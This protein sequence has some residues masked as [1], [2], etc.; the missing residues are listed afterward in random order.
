MHTTIGFKN[1]TMVGYQN[2]AIL[3]K[4]FT[5]VVDGETFY[6]HFV[7]ERA[8]KQQQSIKSTIAGLNAVQDAGEIVAAGSVQASYPTPLFYTDDLAL[9]GYFLTDTGFESVA[10]LTLR[11]FWPKDIRDFHSNLI[12]FLQACVASRKQYLI[13][14][15]Q[16]NPGG[17]IGLGYDVFKQLFPDLSPYAAG[18][19]RSHDQ[20]NI[21]GDFFT[22]LARDVLA[23][24][25]SIENY[26]AAG[27]F[28]IFDARASINATGAKFETWHEF[29]GPVLVHGD[30]FTNVARQDIENTSVEEYLSGFAFSDPPVQPFRSENVIVLADGDCASTCDTFMHLLKW[31]A[32][33]K[34]I[35]GGG[36]PTKGPMQVVGGVKARHKLSIGYLMYLIGIFRDK[37]PQTVQEK[38]N[39]TKL[40]TIF[41]SGEYL[42]RRTNGIFSVNLA[43]AIGKDDKTMT[44]LQFVYE[45]ADCRVWWRPEHFF[46]VRTLWTLVAGTAFGLNNTEM[47][48]AC[49]EGSTNHPSSVTG[50]GNLVFDPN[51]GIVSDDASTPRSE[52]GTSTSDGSTSAVG[53]ADPAGGSAKNSADNAIVFSTALLLTSVLFGSVVA[54]I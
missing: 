30:N 12:G 40:K 7:E 27:G 39:A 19:Q 53:K 37:A 51:S 16:A 46:N 45:A 17:N 24:T 54:A 11:S 6:R 47:W 41:E 25:G 50:G 5:G 31:Q 1:G 35:V 18:N 4:N 33:V 32:K 49:V 15:M 2:K 26:T 9:S 28:S 23:S 10:V 29:D 38:A 52:N 3:L 21:L 34:T 43:N 44:P 13:L 22:E 14:E 20:V 42:A 36:R 48:S 8:N